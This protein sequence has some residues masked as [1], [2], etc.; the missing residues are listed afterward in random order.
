MTNIAWVNGDLVISGEVTVETL[1]ETLYTYRTTKA[2][3]EKIETYAESLAKAV[4][5]KDGSINAIKEVY[6]YIT[7]HPH[8]TPLGKAFGLKEAK[9]MVDRLKQR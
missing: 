8:Y 4:L 3:N 7:N 1:E 5:E 6:Y 2:M 9:E